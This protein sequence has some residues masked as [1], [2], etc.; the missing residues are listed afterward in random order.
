MASLRWQVRSSATEASTASPVGQRDAALAAARVS[1]ASLLLGLFGLISAL[2]VLLRLLESWRVTPDAASHRISIL[3][4]KL[5][6]PT[7]NAGAIV[8]IVLA[9][10]GLT[11][12]AMTIVGAVR[13]LAAM[14]RFHRRLAQQGLRPMRDALVIDDERPQAFCAG[15]IAPRVYVST[16][17][18]ALLDNAGVDAVLAHERHHAIRREPLRHATGRVLARALFLPGL[19]ELSRRQQALAELSADESAIN[20]APSNRSGLAGAILTFS[21]ARPGGYSGGVDVARVD[22]LLGEPPSWRFPLALCLGAAL[23]FA[24]LIAVAALAG[25]VARGSAT[26][27]PPFLSRQPCVVVLAVLPCALGLL[28]A[29]LSRGRRTRSSLPASSQ[30]GNSAGRSSSSATS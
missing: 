17:A 15:L 26:L 29:L 25:Q 11:V 9:V 5:S 20:A 24:L 13:E 2:F 28:A 23:F 30:A 18:L 21:D 10:Y 3:G 4:Q 27:A 8:I 19:K 7:A 6:Y 16:G 1:S 22:F 14:R 12:M